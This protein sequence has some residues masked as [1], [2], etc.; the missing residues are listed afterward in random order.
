MKIYQF[1]WIWFICIFRTQNFL[2]F[3]K[4]NKVFFNPIFLLAQKKQM[5]LD[6]ALHNSHGALPSTACS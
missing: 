3:R 6:T 5:F 1:L 2:Q 4:T